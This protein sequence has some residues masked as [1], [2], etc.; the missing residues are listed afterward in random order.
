MACVFQTC[1]HF[2]FTACTLATAFDKKS[3]IQSLFTCE[4]NM[5]IFSYLNFIFYLFSEESSEYW[6]KFHRYFAVG[7]FI[8]FPP[9]PS[10]LLFDSCGILFACISLLLYMH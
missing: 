4:T 5:K 8:S 9:P 1:L 10:I 2:S 7:I 6:F 3:H